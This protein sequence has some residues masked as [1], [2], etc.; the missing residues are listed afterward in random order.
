MADPTRQEPAGATHSTADDDLRTT[1]S[2]FF[3][4]RRRAVARRRALAQLACAVRLALG[5]QHL[6]VV[7]QAVK[8]RRGELLIPE[9]LHPLTEGE[10]GIR[11]FTKCRAR[12]LAALFWS[13]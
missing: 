7:R 10:I 1:T 2:A 13:S 5:G 11:S 6:R 8:Q 4:A 12:R 3:G 9:H